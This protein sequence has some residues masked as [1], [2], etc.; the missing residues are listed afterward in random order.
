MII[1]GGDPLLLN[2]ERLDWHPVAAARHPARRDH[3]HRQPRARAVLPQRI[4]AGAGARCCASYHPLWIN[5]HFNHPDELHAGGLPTPASRLADAGI[6][7]GSQTVLLQGRQRRPAQ[8]MKAADAPAADDPG[9]ALLHLPVPTWSAAPSHFRTTVA[10][11]PRDHPRA[12]RLHH[13]AAPCPYFVIDAPGGGGKIPLL[14]EYVE[15]MSEDE[16]VLRNFRGERFVYR[17]SREEVG[18]GSG[19]DPEY[20]FQPTLQ[21]KKEREAAGAEEAEDG[22]ATR[23]NERR[24]PGPLSF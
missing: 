12:A 20:L 22:V 21:M 24:S 5:T 4:T 14:P 9:A 10:E 11:G 8:S 19:T 3:P 13:R 17:Q 23:V 6:P 2:D 7:L 16:V 15:S 1:S 18:V